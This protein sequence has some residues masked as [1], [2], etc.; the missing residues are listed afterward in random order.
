VLYTR[1]EINN[2][3]KIIKNEKKLNYMWLRLNQPSA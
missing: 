1:R 2:N 3:K